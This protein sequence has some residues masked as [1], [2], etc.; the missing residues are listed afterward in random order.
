MEWRVR[1][2]LDNKKYL[3]FIEKGVLR[4][5]VY[6][7][8]ESEKDG[9]LTFVPVKISTSTLRERIEYWLRKLKRNRMKKSRKKSRSSGCSYS[10]I[11]R[12]ERILSDFFSEVR[13]GFFI[14]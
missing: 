11:G 5:K 8:K 13:F 6:L 4:M 7:F 3:F 2:Q 14:S 1:F 12:L 10:R 9:S